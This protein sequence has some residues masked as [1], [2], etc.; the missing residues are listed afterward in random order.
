[1]SNARSS[2]LNKLR[3]AIIPNTSA[4]SIPE[5]QWPS[6]TNPLEHWKQLLT[7]NHAQI[8][9]T[10][11]ESLADCIEAW[12]HENQKKVVVASQRI[13]NR[14]PE[15]DRFAEPL[16]EGAI[17]QWKEDL[18]NRVDVGIT[19]SLAA[20]AAT[21]TV[22]IEPGDDEPRSLSLV[23]PCHIVIVS[24]KT[25]FDQFADLLR[26]QCWGNNMPTNRVLISGPSKTAD[27]QQTLAY[28]AHGPSELLVVLI[29]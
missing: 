13:F 4:S 14:Y 8:I 5:Y 26:E 9:E 2:I 22:V 17:E 15:F 24:R 28:G 19:S 18:F 25:F 10:R 23:P 27:I 6:I 7:A 1:M 3:K 21:G 12:L 29:P 16:S 20:I 11:E